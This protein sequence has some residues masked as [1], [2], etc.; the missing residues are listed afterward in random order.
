MHLRDPSLKC[1]NEILVAGA[2]LLGT[3]VI[4]VMGHANCSA[5]K[6]TRAKRFPGSALYPH[7][8]PAVNRAGKIWK[9]P[10]MRTPRFRPPCWANRPR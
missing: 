2:A 4:L 3:K 7:I 10:L 9:P 8:Q 6:A 5:V 1:L